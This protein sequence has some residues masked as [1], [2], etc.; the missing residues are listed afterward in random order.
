MKK[1]QQPGE[2]LRN[3]KPADLNSVTTPKPAPNSR[4]ISSWITL[5]TRPTRIGSS[6]V[7]SWICSVNEHERITAINVEHG[8]DA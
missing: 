3:D 4:T 5:S 6:S 1:P 7:S 2:S 8:E